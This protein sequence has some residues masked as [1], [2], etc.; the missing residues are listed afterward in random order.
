[1]SEISKI[2]ERK[3]NLLDKLLVFL[4]IPLPFY[5]ATSIFIA[6][7]FGSIAGLI[8]IYIILKKDNKKI[9]EQIEKEAIFF[10]LFI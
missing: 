5:L 10:L 9:F 1:M 4:V 6:D 2:F 8:M 3:V 7:F